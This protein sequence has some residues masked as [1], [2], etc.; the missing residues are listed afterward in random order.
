MTVIQAHKRLKA[1]THVFPD[2][3]LEFKPNELGDVVC[4]VQDESAVDR[5]LATPSGFREYLPASA[6][7]PAPPSLTTTDPVVPP[8]DTKPPAPP[9]VQPPP[10]P[11]P[12]VLANGT[13][14]LDLRTLNDEQL[15]AFAKA[16]DIRL[17]GNAKGDKL[18]D[19]IVE[20]L[21]KSE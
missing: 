1:Y 15:R 11:S 9:P 19:R 2:V 14:T 13:D 10:A 18:R 20:A 21:T 6:A 16:N 8:A 17:P 7:K 4:D 3:T 12:Y 5:L